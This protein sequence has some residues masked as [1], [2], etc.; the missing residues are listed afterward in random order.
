MCRCSVRL[1]QCYQS[2][3]IF[4]TVLWVTLSKGDED[5]QSPSVSVRSLSS[6]FGL[7]GSYTEEEP[8]HFVG[9][10][11]ASGTAVSVS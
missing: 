3:R 5:S 8:C 6:G 10:R 1:N 9:K 4:G 11:E 2:S 7:L